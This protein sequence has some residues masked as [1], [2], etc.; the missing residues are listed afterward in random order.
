MVGG[1]DTYKAINKSL[2]E[3]KSYKDQYGRTLNNTRKAQV[4]EYLNNLDADY[5]TKIMMY[6][7]EYTSDDRYNVEIINYLNE[8]EDI[9]YQEMADILTELGF[10]VTADGKIRW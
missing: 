9:S 2:S 4:V 6:K 8:R 3:I 1:Y 5:Y 7:A 10:T